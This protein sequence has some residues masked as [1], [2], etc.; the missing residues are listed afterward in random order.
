MS[1]R[2][3]RSPGAPTYPAGEESCNQSS[4][5]FLGFNYV[6]VPKD[7]PN[8]EE[9]QFFHLCPIKTEKKG[10]YPS[11]SETKLLPAYWCSCLML[12]CHSVHE[13]VLTCPYICLL[14]FQRTYFMYVYINFKIQSSKHRILSKMLD[15]CLKHLFSKAIGIT[16]GYWVAVCIFVLVAQ[17]LL[18][19]SLPR[20]TKM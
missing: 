13:S 2:P 5:Y 4:P 18:K 3:T 8:W 19:I 9:P 11:A 10:T 15:V 20:S 6:S 16:P 7:Q 1:R 12:P 17:L 14:I